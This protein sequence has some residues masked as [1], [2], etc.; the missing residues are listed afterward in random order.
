MRDRALLG[1]INQTPSRGGRFTASGGPVRKCQRHSWH[2][3]VQH[4]WREPRGVSH[5]GSIVI[6]T[7]P[8]RAHA[9]G[10]LAA[11]V[12][13]SRQAADRPPASDSV[14]RESSVRRL[15]PRRL[16]SDR[17]FVLVDQAQ[18]RRRLASL[19]LACRRG[20]VFLVRWNHPDAAGDRPA[21]RNEPAYPA[22]PIPDSF[23]EAA[24]SPSSL[25]ACAP[26]SAG[27]RP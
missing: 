5:C 2:A 26:G 14:C 13:N 15:F 25:P 11:P 27:A 18:I 7:V 20:H 6:E 21:I 16:E 10:K 4:K 9:S 19:R 1:P 12:A 17:S 23:D 3:R 8:G 24:R 22:G